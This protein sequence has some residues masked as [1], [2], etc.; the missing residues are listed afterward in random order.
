MHFSD[1][2][3]SDDPFWTLVT[4]FD[5]EKLK[6]ALPLC[7]AELGQ[8]WFPNSMQISDF[9]SDTLDPNSPTLPLQQLLLAK[10]EQLSKMRHTEK[11]VKKL[12]EYYG[13]LGSQDLVVKATYE[14]IH[15]HAYAGNHQ[16]HLPFERQLLVPN[17]EQL[18]CL[19]KSE[20]KPTENSGMMINQCLALLL[21]IGEA[22]LVM[23][24]GGQ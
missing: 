22:K 18:A 16:V 10:L 20:F 19:F 5:L 9:M 12:Q 21:N 3:Q 23:D 24:K 13:D 7:T 2:I 8:F 11:F 17:P 14:T 1:L 4:S 15:V 6:V